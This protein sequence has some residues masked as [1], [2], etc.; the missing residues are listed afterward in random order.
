MQ[1]IP[2]HYIQIKHYSLPCIPK[3]C[4]PYPM[5]NI[6]LLT[7]CATLLFACK[8]DP[9]LAESRL[10]GTWI[11]QGQNLNA[12]YMVDGTNVTVKGMTTNNMGELT[13]DAA[14]DSFHFSNYYFEILLPQSNTIHT[15]KGDS[16]YITEINFQS[17]HMDIEASYVL[18]GTNSL[19]IAGTNTAWKIGDNKPDY[20][21]YQYRSEFIVGWS[22]DTL[23]LLDKLT[24]VQL[25]MN[26]N[27]TLKF[28]R[29]VAGAE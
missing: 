12:D 10:A 22:G 9:A 28:V 14:T 8:K 23:L 4:N 13:F 18:S 5:R 19:K 21:L 3:R 25:T 7:A 20:P 2:M 1:G 11:F 29:K 26:H 16:T 15:G 27:A 17:P 24:T 6:L